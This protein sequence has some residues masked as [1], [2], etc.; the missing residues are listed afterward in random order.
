MLGSKINRTWFLNDLDAGGKSRFENVGEVLNLKDKRQV[1][2][3]QLGLKD[4]ECEGLR[5]KLIGTSQKSE[6]NRGQVQVK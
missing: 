2:K 4:P 5:N 1:A 3:E 6:N